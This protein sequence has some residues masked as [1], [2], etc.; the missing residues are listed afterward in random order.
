MHPAIDSPKGAETAEDSV[1]KSPCENR[2]KFNVEKNFSSIIAANAQM[3]FSPETW[4][5]FRLKSE[6]PDH[7]EKLPSRKLELE[8][9]QVN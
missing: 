9:M 6:H 1:S 3:G 7:I 4:F 2:I 5:S 8:R